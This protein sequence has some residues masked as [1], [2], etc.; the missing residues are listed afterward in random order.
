VE[1]RIRFCRTPDGVRL[2][3]AVHGRGPLLVRPGTWLTH[4]EYDWAS[5]VWRHWLSELGRSFTVLR[6][7]DRG[8][9]L[10]D[11]DVGEFSLDRWVC[12][13]ETVVDAAGAD[14]FDLLGVSQGAPIGV[15]YAARHPE[16][17]RRMVVY[18]GYA[19][20]RLRR[21]EAERAQAEMLVSLV[22]VGWGSPTPAFRRAFAQLLVPDGTDAEIEPIVELQRMSSSPETAAAIRQARGEIDVS[23]EAEQ[24]TAPTLVL[25]AREDVMVPFEEG[26]RLASLIPDARLVSLEGRNHIMRADD[27][28]W[29]GVVQQVRSFLGQ[30]GRT[31]AAPPVQLTERELDVVRLVT[32]GL[33]NEAIAAELVLSVRTVER[34]L[35]NIY[36]KL[37]VS[38]KAARAAVAARF[39]QPTA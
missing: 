20:G 3:Y 33:D 18:G 21:S 1:Q 8:C 36:N 39:A 32:D 5:P 24:L 31:A 25:H 12:D 23:A 11:R 17:V 7:D 35:S 4:L 2:A 19:R 10:S 27:P 37:G 13:L 9:G 16:R 34:H 26:R 22:R 30:P 15:A 14:R 28:G 29:P 6:Y 38:G